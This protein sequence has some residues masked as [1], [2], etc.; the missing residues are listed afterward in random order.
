M[1]VVSIRTPGP[2]VD[3]SVTL[4]RYL[5]LAA[6]GLA[7]TMLSTSAWALATSESLANEVLPTGA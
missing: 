3:D 2:I 7:F 1:C 5:P 6:G 4:F